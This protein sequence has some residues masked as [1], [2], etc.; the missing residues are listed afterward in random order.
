MQTKHMM[1]LEMQTWSPDWKRKN[2]VL[3]LLQTKDK[4]GRTGWG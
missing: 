2:I 3:L 1:V 4:Q